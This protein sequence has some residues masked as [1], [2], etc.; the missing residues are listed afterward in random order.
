MFRA[1][2]H[3]NFRLFFVGQIISLTGTWMQSLAQSW[4]VYR[5]TQSAALLGA[6]GF[7]S[8]IPVLFLSTYAGIVADRHSRRRI[9]IITQVAMMLQALLM[10][11]L[12]LSGAIQVWHI[13]ALALLLGVCNAFD[14]PARQSFLVEMVGTE[15]LMNAI[16]LNSS[17]FN[18][19]RMVGPA[20]AGILVAAIGEGLCFLLNGLTYLAVIAGLMMMRDTATVRDARRG[21]PLDQLREGIRYTYHNAA[22]RSLL[23]LLGL[24][25]LMALPYAVLMPIFAED[26]LRSGPSGLGGLMTAAGCGALLGAL[27]LARRQHV[28]GLDRV[29]V[30]ACAAFGVGLI[31]FALSR[32][33][34]LS[35]ACLVPAGFCIMVQMGS[36]NSLVQAI[37]ADAMRGRVMGLYATVFLGVGPFG[38]LM[39]GFVAEHF[40]APAA[41]VLGG[42]SCI[43]GA[44]VLGIKVKTLNI[45]AQLKKY[46]G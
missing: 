2:R 26:I 45:D 44:F 15:D 32:D 22:I 33:Y 23:S 18:S 19:A 9:V 35:A 30:R 28:L 29:V 27:W 41:V 37:V 8:Q 36:T 34:W 13:F 46:A 7:T 42:I 3:R 5:L 38:S 11:A 16:A 1:L 31:L 20:V 21:R 17:I 39:A 40:G 14:I 24:V 10:A 25:S 43:I 4:L 12:T 6:V